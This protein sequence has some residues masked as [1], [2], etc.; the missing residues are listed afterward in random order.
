MKE[1]TKF[2]KQNT[3]K[4]IK[5]NTWPI[6]KTITI[7]NLSG[8]L[9]MV[10][11]LLVVPCPIDPKPFNISDTIPTI[12]RSQFTIVNSTNFAIEHLLISGSETV[13]SDSMGNVVTGLRTGA[14]VKISADFK[15]VTPIIRIGKE[16]LENTACDDYIVPHKECGWP[17]GITFKDDDNI[18]VIDSYSGI[19]LVNLRDKTKTFILSINDTHDVPVLLNSIVY[20]AEENT[21]YFTQSSNRPLS[22]VFLTTLEHA[23]DGKLLKYN[24][25]TK[26]VTTLASNFNVAN[27]LAIHRDGESLIMSELMKARIWRYYFRGDKSG[28]IEIFAENLITLPDNIFRASDNGYWV[29]SSIVWPNHPITSLVKNPFLCCLALKIFSTEIITMGAY[30]V[31]GDDNV[32]FKINEEGSIEKTYYDSSRD[33]LT[34]VTG[35]IDTG[36]FLYVGSLNGKKLVRFKI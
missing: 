6:C 20:I 16:P 14:I 4:N 1:E 2:A 36:G 18:F 22:Q 10:A 19:Y 3:S 30:F 35:A 26:E 31:Q 29:G 23:S 7:I 11:I 21:I 28:Q 8:F 9:T 24:L 33:Y 25:N 15:T 5:E 13:V 17:L 32:V 34:S 27:G 12:D